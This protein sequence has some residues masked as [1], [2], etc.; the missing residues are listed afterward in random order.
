MYSSR[1]RDRKTISIPIFEFVA[2]NWPLD[3]LVL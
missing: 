2:G 1:T 3:L